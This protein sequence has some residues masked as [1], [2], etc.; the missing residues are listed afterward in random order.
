M[1]KRNHNFNPSKKF[2]KKN[3]YKL[4]IIDRKSTVQIANKL[5][6][7]DTLIYNRLKEYHIKIR[8]M[9]EG[10][11]LVNIPKLNITKYWLNQKYNIEKLSSRQ[12]A[13]LL[14]C[15]ITVLRKYFKR[16]K[17]K[18]RNLSESVKIS[19]DEYPEL[20]I[21]RAKQL[22]GFFKGENNYNF[23][24]Y[25][26]REP[27]G[28]NWSP[29]LKESIRK[30]DNYTCQN[31]G[32]TEEEHLI[33][34]GKVLTV[35]HIDYIKQNCNKDNLITV[36]LWCNFRAN[37]NRDYWKKYYKKLICARVALT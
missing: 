31:C 20:R 32:I 36:C 2:S 35:H 9:K 37:S 27:Y 24:N 11:C 26:S 1:K 16:F 10:V 25:S 23:N 34:M 3:L 29:E 14:K 30:R 8:T 19:Y 28:I 5:G 18:L 15:S 33:V 7:S 6:C 22:E 13:K 17:I 12:I 21:I 4:Y